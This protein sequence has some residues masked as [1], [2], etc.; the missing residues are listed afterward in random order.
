VQGFSI[1]EASFDVELKFATQIAGNAEPCSSMKRAAALH[2]ERKDASVLLRMKDD[3][4]SA[5]PAASS[6]AY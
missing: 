1:F 4:D 5:E 6:M 2:H 3:N